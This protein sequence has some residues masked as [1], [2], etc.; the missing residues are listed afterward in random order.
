VLVDTFRPRAVGAGAHASD[1]G[2]YAWSWAG[3]RLEEG[4]AGEVTT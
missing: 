1:D 4:P 3:R 2:R